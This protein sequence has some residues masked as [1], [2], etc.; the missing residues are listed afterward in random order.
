MSSP[1]RW[2]VSPD[3]YTLAAESGTSS[4]AVA[5]PNRQSTLGSHNT[6]YATYSELSIEKIRT[7]TIEFLTTGYRP[8]AAH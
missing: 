4:A 2:P 7:A 3:G 6:P 8:T 1:P 5:T